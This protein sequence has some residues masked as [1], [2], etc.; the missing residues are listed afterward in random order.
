MTKIDAAYLDGTSVRC[1]SI[2]PYLPTAG[3]LILG[4]PNAYIVALAGS[5]WYNNCVAQYQLER[6]LG[7]R[8]GALIGIILASVVVVIVL[9]ICIIVPV[10]RRTCVRQDCA[11][12][13]PGFWHS[14]VA[15]FGIER[16]SHACPVC[17]W[18]SQP[19]LSVDYKRE[20]SHLIREE[21]FIGGGSFGWVYRAQMRG[22]EVAIK[23]MSGVKDEKTL[24]SFR[25]E[26]EAGQQFRHCPRVARVLG[27]CMQ[28]PHVCIISEYLPGGTLNTRIHTSS[29]GPM[30]VQE[31]L[32][33][34]RDI[35]EALSALHPS[36]THRDL[37]PENIL[38][39][40]DDRPKLIDFGLGRQRGGDP[41]ITQDAS[42][43]QG[44]P[45]YMAPEMFDGK[46]SEKVDIY[47]LGIIMCECLS[48]EKPFASLPYP[49][50]ICYAVSVQNKRPDIPRRCP[51]LLARLIQ[52]CWDANPLARP[53]AADVRYKLDFI[54][55]HPDYELSVSVHPPARSGSQASCEA[56][57]NE[58][59]AAGSAVQGTAW[60][61]F[62]V[63]AASPQAQ[64]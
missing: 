40:A 29:K 43:V 47:A 35:A 28:P 39:D 33:T 56:G 62:A 4:T 25:R 21:R 16:R 45:A 55:G 8:I 11:H 61:S 64:A 49:S 58:G 12:R 5:Q 34:A 13:H 59:R 46:V 22:C 24:E 3:Q 2:Y 53:D 1:S 9:S 17:S 20:I 44:T 41:F 7:A 51:D 42:T 10:H 18:G 36:Y 50:Q 32:Q 19:D 57:D 14:F 52:Q 15:H 38:L 27:A 54:L 60:E 26:L 6:S 37:K 63:E 23:V 30:A 48:R 31:V